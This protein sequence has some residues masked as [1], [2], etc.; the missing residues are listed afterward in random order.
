MKRTRIK[1]VVIKHRINPSSNSAN[2]END[3]DEEDDCSKVNKT[4]WNILKSSLFTLESCWEWEQCNEKMG[5]G[6]TRA[7]FSRVERWQQAFGMNFTSVKVEI[8]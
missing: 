6:R 1:P 4:F 2:D 8:N 3:S 7:R 5:K